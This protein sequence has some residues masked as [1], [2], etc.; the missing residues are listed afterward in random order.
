MA[1]FETIESSKTWTCP[2]TGYY[3]VICIGGGGGGGGAGYHS[4]G[5]LVTN[6]GTIVARGDELNKLFAFPSQTGGFIKSTTGG[7][8]GSTGGTTSFGSILTASG[9]AG[10]QGGGDTLGTSLSSAHLSPTG[11]SSTLSPGGSGTELSSVSNDVILGT[12]YPAA[13]SRGSNIHLLYHYPHKEGLF[14][15]SVAQNASLNVADGVLS[16]V[17]GAGG[18]GGDV[19]T[20]TV[21]ITKGTEIACTVGSGGNSGAQGN[22]IANSSVSVSLKSDS[23]AASADRIPAETLAGSHHL[24]LLAKVIGGG[25]GGGF[26][27]EC[28]GG[29]GSDSIS[30]S[31]IEGIDGLSH[32]Y[33]SMFKCKVTPP[34]GN[35]GMSRKGL[36][37]GAGGNGGSINCL[38]TYGLSFDISDYTLPTT[39]AKTFNIGITKGS[40]GGFIGSLT[41]FVIP[42]YNAISG[43]DSGSSGAIVIREVS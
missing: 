33:C 11:G 35:G 12:T 32:N 8:S 4:L 24:F 23:G 14:I 1:Y 30:E 3:Q 5:A 6:S 19:K 39:A 20:K 13:D 18:A 40:F 43:A 27:F 36:G 16:A 22:Y 26:T 2:K 42:D 17:S 31:F 21:F 10:G 15:G 38:I 41:K 29:K 34:T 37:Y 28:T 9:G 25:G 7:T